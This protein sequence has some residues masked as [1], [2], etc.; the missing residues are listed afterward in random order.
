MATNDPANY[1]RLS[2]P[3][4]SPE[5]AREAINTFWDAVAAA[6][7][8]SGM[9]DVHVI[10]RINVVSDAGDEGVVITAAHFGNSIEAEAMCAWALGQEAALRESTIGKFLKGGW[11]K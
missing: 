3:F 8:A 1:R 2:E 6:R 9:T 10:V 4:E 7:N 11:G 5:A